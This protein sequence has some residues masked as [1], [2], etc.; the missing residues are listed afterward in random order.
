MDWQ[1]CHGRFN[2]RQ[3]RRCNWTIDWQKV[4]NDVIKDKALSKDKAL[5]KDKNK[6]VIEDEY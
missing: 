1:N 3:K 5:T 6:D 2:Q 4:A